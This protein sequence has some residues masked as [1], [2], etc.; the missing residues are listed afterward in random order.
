MAAS[1]EDVRRWVY[2]GNNGTNSHL[3]VVCDKWDWEDYPVYVKNGEDI[4]KYIS[5][6]QDAQRMS[7]I[8]EIYN[9]SLDLESQLREGHAWH[10]ETIEKRDGIVKS[11]GFN[12]TVL[13][14]VEMVD[15]KSIPFEQR[16]NIKKGY[17]GY[18]D[19]GGTFYPC[20]SIES[21][22]SASYNDGYISIDQYADIIARALIKDEEL[23]KRYKELAAKKNNCI[24]GFNDDEWTPDKVI[25]NELGYIKFYRY[26]TGEHTLHESS[27][28]SSTIEPTIKQLIIFGYLFEINRVSNIDFSKTEQSIAK[29]LDHKLS[30]I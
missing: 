2:G 24:P 29:L 7:G 26:I 10:P 23:L 25:V 6:Y 15:F 21:T 9:Y 22:G 18:I 4:K 12:K 17:N 27:L 30:K 11:D 5:E 20:M 3:I 16:S 14:K 8:N 28:I 13:G 1:Y 19:R